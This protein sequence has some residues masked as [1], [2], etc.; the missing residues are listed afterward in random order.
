MTDVG[1]CPKYNTHQTTGDIEQV[2]LGLYTPQIH[3][4]VCKK[5]SYFIGFGIRKS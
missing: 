4:Y 5:C 3:A 1:K 2:R